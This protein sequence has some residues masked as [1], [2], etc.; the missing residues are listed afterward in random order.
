MPRHSLTALSI[1]A[2][3]VLMSGFGIGMAILYVD[4]CYTP[5]PDLTALYIRDDT[6]DPAIPTSESE[7]YRAPYSLATVSKRTKPTIERIVTWADQQ[8]STVLYTS[9]GI[10]GC[11]AYA[12]SDYLERNLG[13]T[14]LGPGDPTGAY[15]SDEPS[16]SGSYVIGGILLPE[17][18]N[19]P[20]NGTYTSE[21]AKAPFD[22]ADFLY[23][24]ELSESLDGTLYTDANDTQ[25]LEAI[26]ADNG[27][28]YQVVS[29]PS[30]RSLATMARRLLERSDYATRATL[31]SVVSLVVSSLS[32]VLW[33][34]RSVT[35][36]LHIHRA[37][38]LSKRRIIESVAAGVLVTVTTSTLSTLACA[39]IAL[40]FLKPSDM[41]RLAPFVITSCAFLGT[42]L[43][44]VCLH[45]LLRTIDLEE[46]IP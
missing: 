17:M 6:F 33:L 4:Y 39:H 42:A 11:G 20:V 41:V 12:A 5:T 46:A 34:C 7:S 23:S 16:V 3:I 27:F 2:L 15:V 10:A 36:A 18:A 29:K 28:S 40:P 32:L 14:G 26:L 19:L 31:S 13:V 21:A 44:L 25:G 8:K 35:D 43:G 9:Y 22:E 30:F 45:R 38:G 37:F 1:L 24:L